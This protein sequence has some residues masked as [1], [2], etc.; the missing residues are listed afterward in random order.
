[1][2][3]VHVHACTCMYMYMMCYIPSVCRL[4]QTTLAQAW[5]HR[6]RL[7]RFDAGRDTTRDDALR[8]RR[9]SQRVR[10]FR[11][12]CF[13]PRSHRTL[14]Q[15]WRSWRQHQR[16]RTDAAEVL[17]QS[18]RKTQDHCVTGVSE[19]SKGYTRPLSALPLLMSF[20]A[21]CL[22]MHV[23]DKTKIVCS[24]WRENL[25]GT[26]WYS[27]N[28]T[29][30]IWLLYCCFLRCFSDAGLQSIERFTFEQMNLLLFLFAC[31]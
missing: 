15:S 21:L 30:L 4:L 1:M 19:S 6:A 29:S 2:M 17:C 22:Y 26:I 5:F 10:L 24:D 31:F 13:I 9:R 18:G 14:H 7:R 12:V 20:Y 11:V 28:M 27:F 25:W 23:W 16:G 8:V 3:Y